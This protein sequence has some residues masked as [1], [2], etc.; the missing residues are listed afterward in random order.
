MT[1]RLGRG[2]GTRGEPRDDGSRPGGM[3]P[4]YRLVAVVSS[5][6]LALLV[7][8]GPAGTP[9]PSGTGS[10]APSGSIA[11]SPTTISSPEAAAALVVASDPRFTGIRPKDPN[12]IGACC[13]WEATAARDG[14]Q[15]LLEIGWGDCPSGC[16]NR[17]DWTFSV[18]TAGLVT[19][20]SEQG[21]PVPAG[22]GGGGGDG[23]GVI[24]IRG[25]ATA[26]PVCPVVRPGDSNC[27]DRPVVGATI[28][29]LDETGTEVALLETDASGAFVVTLAP[30][31]YR[32]VADPVQGLM[33]SPGPVDVVVG[34][35]LVVVQLTYDTGIR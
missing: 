32:V 34:S 1:T 29:I 11:P 30:G 4:R 18:T 33:H 6:L 17:H 27:L 13:F 24:G 5:G 16:I 26:G 3:T 19:L 10:P 22:V 23:S 7:A 25:I 15:V 35:S 28:H 14:Y 21:P 8:C 2:V 12:V 31:R 9:G 20:V